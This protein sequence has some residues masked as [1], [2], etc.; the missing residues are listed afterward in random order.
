[1]NEVKKKRIGTIFKYTWPLYIVSALVVVAGLNVIFGV[2]HKLADYKQ[3]TLFVSGEINDVNKLEKDLIAKYQEKE[4]KRL[5]C[6]S[7][8]PSSP[9]Y[10]TMF[11]VP[12]VVGS[13]V[14]I[15]TASKL[16]RYDIASFALVLDDSILDKYFPGANCYEYEGVNYAIKID[17]EKVKEYMNLPSED[18]YLVINNSSINIGEYSKKQIKEHNL[19]LTLVQDWR[20]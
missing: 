19:A 17:K 13:D 15:A 11:S 5:T 18:C 12:G 2:T 3:L 14:L 7:V 4:L 16:D 8:D 10:D 1:M 9:T 20:M 6:Y